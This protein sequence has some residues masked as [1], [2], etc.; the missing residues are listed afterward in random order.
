LIPGR[1]AARRQHV[2]V[3]GGQPAYYPADGGGIGCGVGSAIGRREGVSS[4]VIGG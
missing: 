4:A 3:A 2:T 1:L